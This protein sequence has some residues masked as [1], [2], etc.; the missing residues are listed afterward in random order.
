MVTE[1]E[2]MDRFGT[3]ADLPYN[4]I[5]VLNTEKGIIVTDTQEEADAFIGLDITATA[6]PGGFLGWTPF[7]G[8][9][10][11][12]RSVYLIKTDAGYNAPWAAQQL[13]NGGANLKVVE[14]ASVSSWIFEGGTKQSLSALI[15]Q[16][17]M[18]EPA[19]APEEIPC[20]D[21]EPAPT[22]EEQLSDDGLTWEPPVDI[23][24]KLKPPALKTELLPESLRGYVQ[25]QSELIG[26]DPGVLGLS[27]LVVCASSIHDSI[28]IQP[29]EHEYGWRESAR[30]W[31]AVVGIPS[32]KKSPSIKKASAPLKA[33]D[34]ELS[35]DN[36]GAL[37]Q[38]KLDEKVYSKI[39][40]AYIKQASLAKEAG[41]EAP[42]Q[43]PERPE[44]P[45]HPE[46]PRA[47]IGN[48]TIE[49]I[50]EILR[51]NARGSLCLRDELSG[52][53]GAMDAY[54]GKGDKDR[55]LWLEAYNGGPQP[56]DRIGRGSFVVPNWSVSMIGGIQPDK[57][58]KVAAKTDDDGLLQRFI[59][60]VAQEAQDG[61]DRP[62]NRAAAERYRNLV[63]HMFNTEPSTQVIKLSKEALEVKRKLDQRIREFRALGEM[64]LALMSHLAKWEGLFP[65]LLLTYHVI[66]CA[67]KGVYPDAM[68]SGETAA[69]VYKFMMEYLFPHAV[70][71]YVEVLD[72]SD[73]MEHARW[74]AGFILSRSLESVSKRDIVAS[75]R[76][77]RK[78][79]SWVLKNAM[80]FLESSGWIQPTRFTND[81]ATRWD[82][83]PIIHREF[84]SIADS[85]K[86]RREEDR[87]NLQQ[88]FNKLRGGDD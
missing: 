57:I 37:H 48:A 9:F 75:Y 83:N 6:F 13:F 50:S 62:P 7:F 27:C 16:T 41:E 4:I 55:P 79:P 42:K 35:T 77:L 28:Q 63:R 81:G 33:I 2:L 1:S 39:E 22:Y 51:Y 64:S 31:G 20:Y 73:H 8:Q 87:A 72:N 46:C 40:A 53:F 80:G 52:W 86:Q 74:I 18:W 54:S 47:I 12:G 56:I 25:D 66:N 44:R 60:V 34:V 45:E 36:A 82:V 30:L 14:I 58:R 84:K 15:T 3:L 61:V 43:R 24:A 5:S 85:E 71:F 19:P 11:K 70:H 76:A 38:F 23:F 32:V 68:V 26:V 59:V 69:L 78:Q 88:T 49:A 17:P 21:D 10:F 29:K 65:R 67:D